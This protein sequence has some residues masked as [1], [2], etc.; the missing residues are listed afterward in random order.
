MRLKV[1][2]TGSKG[3]AYLLEADG[4]SLL[5][6][7]G[8]SW[9]KLIPE[10]PEGL[11]GLAGC[12]ITHEHFDHAKAVDQLLRHGIKTVISPGTWQVVAKRSKIDPDSYGGLV[13]QLSSGQ[14][15][16]I[17]PFTVMATRAEHDAVDPL[18]FLIRYE[19][20]GETVLYATDTYKLPNRYP[21]INYW[22]VE[23]NYTLE[24]IEA[25]QDNPSLGFL[26]ERLAKS[27][28]S[29]ERLCNSLQANDLSK[30]RSIVL[31]H[32]SQDRGDPERMVEAVH[33]VTGIQTMAAYNGLDIELG[34][35]PF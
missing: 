28:M 1:I 31:V 7:A 4:A 26:Y 29:M 3:N 18:A 6:D 25:M 30:T 35:C 2:G 8:L 27:H 16:Y 23:C 15:E 12:L 34:T 21:G 17:S 13:T 33:S 11:E 24:K 14:H 22:L 5:L 20:T 10:L 9:S 32:I 19:P